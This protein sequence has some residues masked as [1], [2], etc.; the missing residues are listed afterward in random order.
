MLCNDCFKRSTCKKLCPEAERYVS[1]I[2]AKARD[3][4]I[5]EPFREHSVTDLVNLKCTCEDER[6]LMNPKTAMPWRSGY[7]LTKT[8][9]QILTLLAKGFSRADVCEL[10]NISRHTL[11][12]HLS[13]TK[14]KREIS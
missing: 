13:N 12:Q 3:L 10:M 1:Q 5:A 14:K 11:R 7:H 9:K 6:E 4:T 8:E 2:E